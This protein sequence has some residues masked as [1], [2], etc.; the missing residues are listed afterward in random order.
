MFLLIIYILISLLISR[1]IFKANIFNIASLA[2]ISYWIYYPIE[3][4]AFNN[5]TL[6]KIVSSNKERGVYLFA[7]FGFAF[8]LG[9]FFITKLNLRKVKFLTTVNSKNNLLFISIFLGFLGFLCFS[10]T[11]NFDINEYF[12]NLELPRGER[13][14]LLSK[15][16]NALPYSIFF[17]PSVTTLLISIKKFGLRK[18]RTNI[19]YFII[20]IINFPILLSY[21]FEGDRT[22][23]IKF[24]VVIVFT[25]RLTNTS[26]E[27]EKQ[28]TYLIEKSR[29]NKKV[30]FNRIKMMLILLALFFMLTFIGIG[31]NNGWKY[32]GINFTKI[33]NIGFSEFRYVNFT[34]D[35]ALA[36]DSLGIEKT[37]KI[38]TW[39]KILFYPLP[40]YVY[41]SIFNEKKPPNIGN[42]I[43]LETK[44]FIFGKDNDAKFGF[45]LSP[46][47]EGFIN[48]G[49]LGVFITGLI[50][51]LAVGF[52]QSFYNKISLK[53]VDL[54][55][56]FILNTIGMLPL[57]MRSGSA[58]IYN[59]IFS[60]SFVILLP[61][62]IIDIYRR[63]NFKKFSN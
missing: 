22:S 18:A 11:Y 51:G 48:L 37:D 43:A 38:F 7:I 40:T 61:L 50:Y 4:F 60:T 58:G 17:I 29:I 8:L 34:I 32:S 35:F 26:V 55:D 6:I 63:K 31:R 25:L 15:A 5:Q 53:R 47:A 27:E 13:M 56:I 16:S 2:L 12:L 39:D 45:A 62:L 54:L 3:K 28:A 30:L 36:R 9:A 41:K 52:L 20:T 19:L 57:I 1:L 21:I 46:I 59:W 24:V 10:Y 49:H 44:N 33:S 42:A 23:L 14:D